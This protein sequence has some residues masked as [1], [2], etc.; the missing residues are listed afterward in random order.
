MDPWYDYL[1]I[2]YAPIVLL[3]QVGALFIRHR[4]KRWGLSLACTAV[5]AAMF[6]YVESLTLDP[7]EGVNI[8]AGV[9]LLWLLVSILLLIAGV[10]R[11]V[12]ELALRRGRRFANRIAKPS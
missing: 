7:D 6:F 9:L 8:G 1:A 4:L 12:V 10:M 3:V 11:D 5:I 2:P